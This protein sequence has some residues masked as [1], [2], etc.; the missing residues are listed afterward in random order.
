MKRRFAFV[1]IA[2][3]VGT[4]LVSPAGAKGRPSTDIETTWT[5]QVTVAWTYVP[6]GYGLTPGWY[7][8]TVNFSG[9]TANIRGYGEMTL[10]GWATVMSLS[11]YGEM[12]LAAKGGTLSTIS[13]G[14]WNP[15]ET[16]LTLDWAGPGNNGATGMFT[17][18]SPGDPLGAYGGGASARMFYPES[19]TPGVRSGV[20]SPDP[21]IGEPSPG[22]YTVTGTFTLHLEYR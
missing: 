13:D 4:L 3:F 7:G 18:V 9:Q 2:L 8:S 10:N 11:T 6:A 22:P 5:G 20:P 16:T 14:A 21:S 17:R 1:L 19:Q 15:F 12:T